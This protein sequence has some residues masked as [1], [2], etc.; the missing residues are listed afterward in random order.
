MT[1]RDDVIQNQKEKKDEIYRRRWKIGIIDMIWRK[2]RKGSAKKVN[3][4][5]K[6]DK[7][8]FTYQIFSRVIL[9]SIKLA[10]P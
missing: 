3:E 2:G 8:I 9:A 10:S 4:D 1:V 7:L 5:N 6:I